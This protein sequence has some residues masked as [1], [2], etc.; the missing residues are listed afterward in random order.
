MCRK[1]V[2]E[3]FLRAMIRK[4]SIEGGVAVRLTTVRKLTYGLW[5][6]MVL[7]LVIVWYMDFFALVYPAIGL[8]I[9]VFVVNHL[10]WKCPHCGANLGRMEMQNRCH[11]CGKELEM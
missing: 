7:L 5:A 9:L 4:R 10:F 6:L 11:S 8:V 2:T 3:D 1:S